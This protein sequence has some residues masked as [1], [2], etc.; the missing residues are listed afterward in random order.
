M[1]NIVW[2]AENG[3]HDGPE[4]TVSAANGRIVV[5]PVNGLTRETVALSAQALLSGRARTVDLGMLAETLRESGASQGVT[6][7]LADLLG[8]SGDALDLFYVAVGVSL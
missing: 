5:T 2:D 1:S 4:V 6:D 8:L 7:S 3:W